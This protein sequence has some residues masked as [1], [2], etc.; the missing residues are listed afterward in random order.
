MRQDTRVSME[1]LVETGGKVYEISD[2]EENSSLPQPS[3]NLSSHD[4]DFTT[5]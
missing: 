1:F 4:T 3:L 5:L 2:I